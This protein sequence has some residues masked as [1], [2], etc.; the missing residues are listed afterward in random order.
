M[1]GRT[2]GWVL[3]L[4]LAI[5]GT[6]WSAAPAMAD[7]DRGHDRRDRREHRDERRDR[8]HDHDDKVSVKIGIGGG[9][10]GH[11]HVHGG[12]RW[13]E[14]HYVTREE[15]VMVSPGHYEE[16]HIPAVYE[17]RYDHCG[18]PYRVLVHPARCERVWCPPR[19]ETRVT[20]VWVPGCWE[21]APVYHAAPRR[22]SG[23]FFGFKGTFRD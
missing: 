17:T 20:R 12:R 13:V 7:R 19:Y 2:M 4:G 14:G 11:G 21:E 23:F 22:D 16:R 10:H 6:L 5:G 1:T 15:R 8:G 9:S 18:E 3:G